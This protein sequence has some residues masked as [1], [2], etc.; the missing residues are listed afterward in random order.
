M[1]RNIITIN[2][3]IPYLG[4]VV[5]NLVRIHFNYSTL[6]LLHVVL[7]TFIFGFYFIKICYPGTLIILV[8]IDVLTWCIFHYWVS[9]N[10]LS[11]YNMTI[12]TY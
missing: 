2:K 9:N 3:N 5:I 1:K 8:F 7:I 4:R 12:K 10:G 11:E 6:Y